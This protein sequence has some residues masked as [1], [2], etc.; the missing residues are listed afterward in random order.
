MLSDIDSIADPTE[1]KA[2][3]TELTNWGQIPRQV[4]KRLHP[5]RKTDIVAK[6]FLLFLSPLTASGLH[7]FRVVFASG[8]VS[9]SCCNFPASCLINGNFGGRREVTSGP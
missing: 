9:V 1:R 6:A 2:R 4:F 8:P 7:E 3:V 5:K